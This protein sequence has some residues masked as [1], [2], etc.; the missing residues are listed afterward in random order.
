MTAGRGVRR[1]F[2]TESGLS[3]ASLI[4]LIVTLVNHEWIEA[5]F[6]VDP[7]QRNGSLEWLVTAVL[8][9]VTV[10]GAMSARAEWRRASSRVPSH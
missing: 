6:G 4:L 2:Y 7:D 5:V 8:I 3:A 1:R 9:V 10:I